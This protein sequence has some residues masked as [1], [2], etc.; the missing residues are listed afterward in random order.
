M[1]LLSDPVI[2]I[3]EPGRTLHVSFVGPRGK[4]VFLSL[5]KLLNEHT[6]HSCFCF[7]F[8]NILLYY[9]EASMFTLR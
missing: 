9:Y 1:G 6:N 2:N 8:C 3:E 4:A 5:L 7:D